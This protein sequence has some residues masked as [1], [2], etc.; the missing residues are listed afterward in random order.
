MTARKPVSRR[1]RSSS[2]EASRSLVA[3][4]CANHRD[5]DR[6]GLSRR[7]AEQGLRHAASR[8]I[9]ALDLAH[10]PD[11]R[12][13][14]SLD[15]YAQRDE[16]RDPAAPRF[17]CAG[18]RMAV[19]PAA[20]PAHDDR[21]QHGKAAPWSAGCR[22]RSARATILLADALHLQGPGSSP[23]ARRELRAG[24]GPEP[25]V[26]AVAAQPRPRT[27]GSGSSTKATSSPPSGAAKH[28]RPRWQ[29]CGWQNESSGPAVS[30]V[31]RHQ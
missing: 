21:R 18:W 30:I 4:S 9:A 28:E 8:A 23:A 29:L 3:P 31:R 15:A 7:F 12:T 5:V 16:L 20:P 6:A 10:A 14:R 25:A 26:S 24:S 11:A 13:S 1:R 22:I 27:A 2:S 19:P 17:A